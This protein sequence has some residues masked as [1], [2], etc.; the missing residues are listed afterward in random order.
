MKKFAINIFILIFTLSA[1]STPLY[2]DAASSRMYSNDIFEM[3]TSLGLLEEQFVMR[4]GNI[5]RADFAKMVHALSGSMQYNSTQQ[6]F[7][8]VEADDD[9]AAAIYSLYSRGI[10][11]GNGDGYF[12]PERY[13]TLIEAVKICASLIGYSELENDMGGYPQAYITAAEKSR[14]TDNVGCGF[15]D[16]LDYKGALILYYNTLTAHYPKQESY[17]AEAKYTLENEGTVLN[18][19]FGIYVASGVVSSNGFTSLTGNNICPDD[20]IL[21]D[22]ESYRF[23]NGVPQNILGRYVD[24]Y[25]KEASPTKRVLY[26]EVNRDMNAIS[27]IEVN[28]IYYDDKEFSRT[29][30]VYEDEE[31]IRKKIK[32][33]ENAD[34]ILNNKAY[35]EMLENDLR[36]ENGYFTLIDNNSDG[37]VDVVEIKSYETYVVNGINHISGEIYDYFGKNL[38]I[39]I[40]KA[41]CRL[42]NNQGEEIQFDKIVKGCIISAAVSSDGEYAEIIVCNEYLNGSIDACD[43]TTDK[44]SINDTWY[45]VSETLMN[46]VNSENSIIGKSVLDLGTKG[47]FYLSFDG[48]VS[49]VSI[50]NTALEYGYLLSGENHGSLSKVIKLKIFTQK[51]ETVI[52]ECNDKLKTNSGKIDC[53]DLLDDINFIDNNIIVQQL[54]KFSLNGAG[55][56]N[57]L[58]YAETA[59]NDY[60]NVN[61]YGI[62]GTMAHRSAANSFDDYAASQATMF[63][64]EKRED[65]GSVDEDGLYIGSASSLPD[66]DKYNVMLYDY[67]YCHVPHAIVLED[68][69]TKVNYTN[70]L[71]VI[72]SVRQAAYEDDVRTLIRGYRNGSETAYYL[73]DNAEA[74]I[75]CPGVD[76]VNLKEGDIILPYMDNN[77]HIVEYALIFSALDNTSDEFQK[78]I[79]GSSL[80]GEL[81]VTYAEVFDIEDAAMGI[82]YNGAITGIPFSSSGKWYGYNSDERE[83]RR[84]YA[85]SPNYIKTKRSHGTGSKVLVVTRRNQGIGIVIVD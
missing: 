72:T 53:I 73:D 77:G 6:I 32:I 15:Y 58:Y 20:R 9:S 50:E 17:G 60:E 47:R 4:E 1:I 71:L 36:I 12:Y 26:F 51:G 79:K 16:N 78:F 67:G 83:G 84:V 68:L 14:L 34:Y 33:D 54:V 5:S 35:V 13:I 66:G 3:L 40:D 43:Y 57:E 61:F 63:V 75:L 52:Y 80:G 19:F 29:C 42:Y 11:K 44:I 38:K 49:Y 28:D 18:D 24:V 23:E 59:E 21:I 25:Y 39:D 55:K 8:D 64:I 37:K 41:K 2:A 82:Y 30:F 27:V 10:I 65:D 45:S 76:T 22:G 81:A 70:Q 56:I 62:S 85:A 46:D 7:N 74:E 31:G 69:D 48:K